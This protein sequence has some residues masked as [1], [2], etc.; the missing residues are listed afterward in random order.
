MCSEDNQY[1]SIYPNDISPLNATM[2]T[3]EEVLYKA[4]E[5]KVLFYGNV[6]TSLR[7]YLLARPDNLTKI[8]AADNEL[9]KHLNMN[10]RTPFS[11]V[12]VKIS[13]QGN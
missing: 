6:M 1:C 9:R 7:W 12:Y 5:T 13:A 10:E 4:N 8:Y 3:F 11:M 2:D